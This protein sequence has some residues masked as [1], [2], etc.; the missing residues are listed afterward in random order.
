VTATLPDGM[1]YK[2]AMAQSCADAVAGVGV[3]GSE[4]PDEDGVRNHIVAVTGVRDEVGDIIV[5]GAFIKTLQ[6]LTPK[7]CIGHDWNRA[8]GDPEAIEEVMPGDPRLPRE[9]RF[10]KPWNPRAGA[11]FARTRYNLDKKDGREAYSDAKFYGPRLATSIGY[12]DPKDD[13]GKPLHS[14]KKIDPDT[15]LMTRFLPELQLFE[16]SQVLHGAHLLA[17]GLK[18][19]M[20]T[21]LERKQRPDM[22]LKVRLVRDSSYWGLPLGTPIRPG[23]KPQG[24]KARRLVAAGQQADETAGAVEVDANNLRIEPTAKGKQ[25]GPTAV[26]TAY[27][28]VIG[29]IDEE[30]DPFDD[31]FTIDDDPNN[32]I[33][34]GEPYNPLD[35]LIA[36]AVPPAELE[37]DLRNADWDNDRL[38]DAAERQGEIDSYI[39]DVTDAYRE[40]YNAELVR[41]NDTGDSEVAD[42]TPKIEGQAAEVPGDQ[43]SQEAGPD[44]VSASDLTPGS[45]FIDPDTG[46]TVTVDVAKPS[47]KLPGHMV[48]QGTDSEGEVYDAVVA[49]DTV[50]PAAPQPQSSKPTP[51]EWQAAQ[52]DMAAA[53]QPAEDPNRPVVSAG[54]GQQ[55][56]AQQGL[57]GSK[58][59]HSGDPVTVRAV[60]GDTAT[61]HNARTEEVY[62]VPAADLLTGGASP[63]QPTT[64]KVNE[65]QRDALDLA[66]GSGEPV[67]VSGAELGA[68]ALIVS[69]I[70]E[71]VWTIDTA[72]EVLEDNPDRK[73]TH[74]R[75][76]RAMRNKIAKMAKPGEPL[77]GG[78]SEDQSAAAAEGEPIAAPGA[79]VTAPAT[80]EP[81]VAAP[82]GETPESGM[83][84]APPAPVVPPV[85]DDVGRF[86]DGTKPSPKLIAALGGATWVTGMRVYSSGGPQK[87]AD[88]WMVSGHANTLYPLHTKKVGT[89][90]FPSTSE[91]GARTSFLINEE[92]ARLLAPYLPNGGQRDEATTPEAL[93][94]NGDVTPEPSTEAAP[95]RGHPGNR[96]ATGLADLSDAELESQLADS[97]AQ[98]QKIQDLATRLESTG[99]V[100][101][102]VRAAQ[103]AAENHNRALEQEA[104]RRGTGAPGDAAG[105]PVPNDGEALPAGD[106]DGLVE[107]IGQAQTEAIA[108]DAVIEETEQIGASEIADADEIVDAGFG[109]TEAPDGEFEIDDDIADRQDR[110]ASLLVQAEAGSLDLS[111]D[112]VG[113]DQLRTTRADIV[114]ELRLQQHLERRRTGEQA[115]SRQRSDAQAADDLAPQ[116]GDSEPAAPE[117]TGPKPR[118]GVAGAAEDLADALESGSDDRIDAATDRFRKALNR[119]RS[120]SPIVAELRAMLAP[121]SGAYDP[122]ALRDAAQRLREE[123][124]AKRNE[125]ARRRR[126]A[127]RFERERLRS[128]LGQVEAEMRNRDLDYDPIPDEDGTV[129][130]DLAVAKP[131]VWETRTERESWSGTDFRL[132]EL[133]GTGYQASI[134][135]YGDRPSI[136]GARTP[137]YAWTVVA[138][139]GVVLAT[140]SGAA[141]DVDS[142]QTTIEIALDTQR[143]LGLIPA[144]AQIPQGAV[145]EDTSAT[146]HADIV[147]AVQRMQRKIDEGR[148]YNPITGRPDPLNQNLPALPVVAPIYIDADQARKY[149]ESRGATDRHGSKL[150]ESYRWDTAKLTPGA[151]L[152]VVD[153]LKGQPQIVHTRSGATFGVIG[154]DLG[155]LSRADLLRY[156]TIAEATRDADGNLVDWRQD[157]RD[158]AADIN[159]RRYPAATNNGH[160]GLQEVALD[161]L[162]REK[163]AAGAFTH[164]LVL[165]GHEMIDGVTNPTRREFVND[166]HRALGQIINARSG[167]VAPADKKT[168]DTAKGARV[169]AAMGAPDAAAALLTRRAA[170]LDEQFEGDAPSHGSALLR[171]LATGYLGMFSPVRSHGERVGDMKVGERLF[172]EE[173]SAD[174]GKPQLRSFRALAPARRDPRGGPSDLITPVI[175]EKTGEQKFLHTDVGQFRVEDTE[176][177]AYGYSPLGGGRSHG[178]YAVVGPGEEMPETVDDLASRAFD[179]V[180]AIP[181]DVL[182]A[183]AEALPESRRETTVRRAAA[184][185]GRRAPRRGTPR[186]PKRTA[187]PLAAPE[188][189]RNE[190]QLAEAQ[191]RTLG[192]FLGMPFEYGDTP[193]NG[194]GSIEAAREHLV[195]LEN[196]PEPRSASSA[197]AVI[198]FIDDGEMTLSPGGMFAVHKKTGLVTHLPSSQRV[199]PP[200][201]SSRASFEDYVQAGG[202][203][204]QSIGLRVARALESGVFDGEQIDWSG[205]GMTA[206]TQTNAIGKRNG[207]S[208]PLRTAQRAAFLDG[209]LGTSKKPLAADATMFTG[210]ADGALDFDAPNAEAFDNPVDKVVDYEGKNGYTADSKAGET[211]AKRVAVE[212]RLVQPLAKAA[213]LDAVRR[214]TRL[215]DELDGK[216]V[217]MRAT[218]RDSS[219]DQTLTLTPSDDL[220][221]MASTITDVYDPKKISTSALFRQAGMVGQVEL[222]KPKISSGR[223]WEDPNG[224]VARQVEQQIT[225]AGGLRFYRDE[226]GMLHATFAGV[227]IADGQHNGRTFDGDSIA[228]NGSIKLGPDGRLTVSYSRGNRLMIIDASPRSWT[229]TSDVP[230]DGDTDGDSNGSETESPQAGAGRERDSGEDAGTDP[231]NETGAPEQADDPAVIAENR[232]RE[233]YAE[234]AD[235]P[236]DFVRIARIRARLGDM[237][238]ATVDAALLAMMETGLVHL[239][240][241]SNT[242]VLTD[243]DRAGALRVGSEDMHLIAIEEE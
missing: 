98:L 126:T 237:D 20:P 24:P 47:D 83:A 220:R 150:V 17:G 214:L 106:G 235:G 160:R 27:S 137:T 127:R 34:K 44:G 45:T 159:G 80:M 123:Q 77:G 202:L 61:V 181:Q 233:L 200:P 55:A 90:A 84:E 135:S 50:L 227:D 151:G 12:V 117:E 109:V 32:K 206:V 85:G 108:E 59:M 113:D 46:N 132:D 156:A 81:D 110:V 204:N 26:D 238:K 190:Q 78:R 162:T 95:E 205:D 172:L 8:I 153:D 39:A 140:G 14:Y 57:I 13:N 170:E 60:D 225:D 229:F 10:G 111:R 221:A 240:P 22:E 141:P 121:E 216:T 52:A 31:E 192:A 3:W 197:R 11:L 75:A 215:A 125:G 228:L 38:G 168:L 217:T 171:S 71:A 188:P 119:S 87:Q 183:A 53:G 94:D 191:G 93:P 129:T 74:G 161:R 4:Y 72:I 41:Q 182:D 131:V 177:R 196:G 23:M 89:Q 7:A 136:H 100:T 134:T 230:D 51:E 19:S 148:E 128:L 68:D 105:G 63:D 91:R 157:G 56:P 219:G 116:E 154:T 187:E 198:K 208:H 86:P 40:K 102:A 167:R 193:T 218:R 194:F 185:E 104:T 224:V 189:V 107:D 73:R 58:A 155:K 29:M 70:A 99:G 76:L 21:R 152:A 164:P 96:P 65:A 66:F 199:W 112:R 232:I 146:P 15:G 142:A 176:E 223:T 122:D 18:T 1:E 6:R 174:G 243:E 163:I 138:D 33:N 114:D 79:D 5:P 178:N 67:E 120:D 97:R 195:A 222:N 103:V 64:V 30:L 92:G 179:D 88:G 82:E 145:S 9:D 173:R 143:R 2:N 16:Y 37:E 69:N 54:T 124:R 209:V 165:R 133:N 231:Q 226:N 241:E 101:D 48:V 42:G 158:L 147:D 239:A 212:L 139:D 211:T 130:L 36:N 43:Q 118:P 234:I 25:K 213:P 207:G 236:Q 201:P 62:E 184:E 144:D 166:Q 49:T 186:A 35:I 28:F 203:A 180:A 115:V 149:L 242:K 175:D 169:L 210:A